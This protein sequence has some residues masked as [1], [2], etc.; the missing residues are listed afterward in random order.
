M[1]SELT[2]YQLVQRKER[3][4]DAVCEYFDTLDVE[5][6]LEDLK[7]I[8]SSE[9][10]YHSSRANKIAMFNLCVFVNKEIPDNG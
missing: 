3:L 1:S 7:E 2:D 8:A 6:L 10:D 9:G 5:W 4:R